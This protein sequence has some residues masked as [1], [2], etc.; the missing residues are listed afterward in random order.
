[1]VLAVKHRID[2]IDLVKGF[3][4]ILVIYGHNLPFLESY[5][6][7]FHMP[8]FFFISGLLHSKKML[9]YA[10]IKKRAKQILVPYFLWSMLLFL[11]WFFIGRKY[12][13]SVNLDLSVSKNFLGIFY[14][15]G[16]HEFMNWGL[17]MWFL[18][19][20]FLNFLT[21]GCIRLLQNRKH[22]I[23]VVLCL[24]VFGFLI[25]SFFDT[26][27]IWSLDVSF[28][29]LFFY[30]MAFYLKDFLLSSTIK[31]E[32][33]ILVV[34]C[35]VHALLSLS[36]I[37]K[38]D[39]YRSIYG[40]AFL[41]LINATLGISFWVLF[42]KKVKKLPFLGFFGKNTLPL[43]AL[44][45]RALTFIK[46]FLLFFC[47]TVSFAFNEYEKIM[48]VVLQLIIL[49]PVIIFINKKAPI[50]NGKSNVLEARN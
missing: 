49:Y 14:A 17:P 38:V 23:A 3:G 31:Y 37:G 33:I 9:N 41:F 50:L 22:Q 28:V 13:D 2:W 42:F 45:T 48:L 47:G 1:M 19:A 12:G 21:F 43:L 16:G 35:I 40:N 24:V 32:A 46:G 8:L 20:I 29:S 25:S 26:H 10:I 15:Q 30:A 36:S 7:T 4:I 18:P 6:Y 5:I 34:V 11:F 39:M 27:L 44:H